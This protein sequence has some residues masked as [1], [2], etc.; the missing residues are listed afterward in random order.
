MEQGLI[1]EAIKLKEKLAN[2]KSSYNEQELSVIRAIF[3]KVNNTRVYSMN[4]CGGSL[5]ET[6]RVSVYNYV[7]NLPEV[8]I[9]E[10]KQE[11]KNLEKTT[12]T[13]ERQELMLEAISIA[14]KKGL[15]K[16]NPNMGVVKLK[17][18]INKN[19]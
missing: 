6:F 13:N 14:S 8:D 7:N 15:R 4:S 18:F 19:K 10:P 3:E 17:A 16:P 9:T 11:V 12:T 1:K 5:C 2:P